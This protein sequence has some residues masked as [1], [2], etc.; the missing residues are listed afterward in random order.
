MAGGYIE[1]DVIE[2]I[3]VEADT[4]GE[5][6]LP[7]GCDDDREPDLTALLAGCEAEHEEE[8]GEGEQAEGV[9][10]VNVHHARIRVEPERGVGE[11]EKLVTIRA[12]P[13]MEGHG[14][15]QQR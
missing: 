3:P 8:H 15:A 10:L 9:L 14:G 4:K 11:Q 12:Q 5:V 13:V 6:E 2:A 1:R 7:A